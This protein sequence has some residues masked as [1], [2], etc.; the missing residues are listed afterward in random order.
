MNICLLLLLFKCFLSGVA[1]GFIVL[2]TL[3]LR[4]F[5]WV[6][7]VVCVLGLVLLWELL[8]DCSGLWFGLFVLVYVLAL[9]AV[10]L[11]LV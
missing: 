1:S 4:L 7:G 5:V 3:R 2:C 6:R 10:L 9:A 8:V 11:W